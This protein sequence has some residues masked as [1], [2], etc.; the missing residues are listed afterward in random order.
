M[1]LDN[2]LFLIIHCPNWPPF[3]IPELQGTELWR[4]NSGPVV[5]YE[6]WFYYP[7]DTWPCLEKILIHKL[8][9]EV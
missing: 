5:F 9:E 7:E 4:Y 8:R 2:F 3:L 1:Q 6:E